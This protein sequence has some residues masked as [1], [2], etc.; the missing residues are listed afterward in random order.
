MVALLVLAYGAVASGFWDDVVGDLYTAFGRSAPA[1]FVGWPMKAVLLLAVTLGALMFWRPAI[2]KWWQEWRQA[3]AASE[4]GAADYLFGLAGGDR[5]IK[6]DLGKILSAH[7][8]RLVSKLEER[9][10]QLRAELTPQDRAA[11]QAVSKQ[12]QA[13]D[14][15]LRSLNADVSRLTYF[16]LKQASVAALQRLI[17]AAPKVRTEEELDDAAYEE[18]TQYISRVR[19]SFPDTWRQAFASEAL[20]HAEHEAEQAI[21]YHSAVAKTLG[22]AELMQFRRHL[23][24]NMQVSRGVAFLVAEKKKAEEEIAKDGHSLSDQFNR[25]NKT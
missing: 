8:E 21:Q 20:F 5:F 2:L 6:G 7:E 1:S 16:A 12:I 17:E 18:Q 25:R 14:D 10:Q 9:A 4:K 23:I 24:A 22:P 11:A 15:A 3:R 13:Q 19:S